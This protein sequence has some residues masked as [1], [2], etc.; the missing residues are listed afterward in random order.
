MVVVFGG[1]A[2]FVV[3]LLFM[4]FFSSRTREE[5][6]SATTSQTA[7]EKGPGGGESSSETQEKSLVGSLIKPVLRK[8]PGKTFYMQVEWTQKFLDRAGCPGG[9]TQREFLGLENL[10]LALGSSGMV[11]IG[12]AL[13]LEVY[14]TV[15][16]AFIGLFLI[17]G[18]PRKQLFAIMAKRQETFRL[19]LPEVLKLLTTEAEAGAGVGV[20]VAC[21]KLVERI[22]GPLPDEFKRALKEIGR[23][24]LAPMLFRKWPRGSSTPEYQS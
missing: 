5:P 8:I 10:S 22:P 16:L 1:V 4:A 14:Q 21:D 23:G 7:S 3:F 12:T 2:G 11:A 9:L 15:I 17:G 18:I 6:S 24:K 13:Q 20:E 19:Q